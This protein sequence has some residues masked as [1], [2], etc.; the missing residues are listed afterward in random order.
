MNSSIHKIIDRDKDKLIAAL[1]E[2]VRIPSTEGAPEANAP[3]GRNVRLALDHALAEGAKL[4]FRT[5]DMEGYVGCIEYGEGSEMVGVVCHLDVVPEGEGWTHDPY[6][7]EIADGNMYGRGTLDD[8]GPAF[9]AL[10]A[11]AAI[12]ESGIPLRRRI[13][14]ILGTN[15]ETGWGCMKYYAKHGEA[16]TLGFT[17]DGDYPLVNSEKGICQNDFKKSFRSNIRVKAGTRPNVVAGR[18]DVF[19]PVCREKVEKAIE[20]ARLEGFTYEFFDCENGTSFRVNGLEAHG[21]SP[22]LGKNSVQAALCVLDLLKLEGEDG[23]MVSVLHKALGMSIHGEDL[24]LDVTDASGRLTLNVGVIDWD[25]NGINSLQTDC[26]HPI[27]VKAQHVIDTQ[28][29]AYGMERVGGKCQ[30][31]LFVPA[32]SELVTKLLDVYAA[33]TGT[34][35]APKAIGGGTYARAFKNVVAFGAEIPGHPA[36]IHMPDEFI[37]IEDLMF[38]AHVIADAMVALAE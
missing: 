15:E 30:D 34:R 23:E 24:G 3:F 4:G 29:K 25:E 37:P 38:D 32:D 14:I 12:K 31:P 2:N 22:E 10:Y 7:A 9:C 6:G 1:Q 13:R 20:D 33:H 19:V 26:R 36:P 8:K 5:V 35:P 16:P 18:T 11:M 27:S 28:V 17:P 21:A